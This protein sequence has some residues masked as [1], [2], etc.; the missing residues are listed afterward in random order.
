MLDEDGSQRGDEVGL[1][2][3]RSV[4]GAGDEG[5]REGVGEGEGLVVGGAGAAECAEDGAGG[6]FC[7][8]VGVGEG[9][10]RDAGLEEKLLGCVWTVLLLQ[11]MWSGASSGE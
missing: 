7:G 1:V 6:H 10:V 4:R 2:G 11:R 3:R 5:G 8:L 9:G